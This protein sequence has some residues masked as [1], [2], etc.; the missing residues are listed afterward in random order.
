MT[1]KIDKTITHDFFKEWANQCRES[2]KLPETVNYGKEI[3]EGDYIVGAVTSKGTLIAAEFDEIDEDTEVRVLYVR[4][5][6]GQMDL[7]TH[8]AVYMNTYPVSYRILNKEEK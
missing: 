4:R 8:G 2:N 3:G 1:P 5:Q 6:N 7:I